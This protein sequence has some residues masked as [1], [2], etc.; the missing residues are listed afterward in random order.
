MLDTH[1]I[2]I[3]F[4]VCRNECLHIIMLYSNMQSLAVTK[5]VSDTN[6]GP[7]MYLHYIDS[8]AEVLPLINYMGK[9]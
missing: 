8:I 1:Y 7:V 2:I 4:L 6:Y 3:I 9:K 5:K